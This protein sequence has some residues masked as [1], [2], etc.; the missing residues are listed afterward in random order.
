MDLY[1]II[2]VQVYERMKAHAAK[3]HADLNQKYDDLEYS[4]HLFSVA[5]QTI[6]LLMNYY[7]DECP[8]DDTDARTVIIFAALFHDSIEDARLTYNDVHKIALTYMEDP[9]AIEAA[10]IVYALTNEKGRTRAER[11]NEKYYEGIR[12]TKYAV[13]IKIADRLSNVRYSREKGSG[14]YHKYMA[15]MD[16]FIESLA[17]PGNE[18]GAQHI[19]NIIYS[20][21]DTNK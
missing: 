14:M 16:H 15:E 3:V 12:N 2:P 6:T 5:E 1:N 20:A 9:Y 18:S 13:I 11:A 17:G 10:E 21:L 7:A 19:R 4:Y 8:I